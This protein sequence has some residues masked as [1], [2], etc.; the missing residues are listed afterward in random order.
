MSRILK[1]R[2]EQ[3]PMLIPH[4]YAVAGEVKVA[5]GDTDYIPPFF[6]K[7]PSGGT[8]NLVDT[9]YRINAGTSAT[10][11]LQRNGSD[12]TGYTGI[13]VT[14]TS[15]DTNGP[16]TALSNNDMIALVVTSVSG[17]PTNMSFTLFLQY[18]WI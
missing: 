13:S 2:I 4:T 12:I 14:T 8:A 3:I 16:D 7:I 17:T 5:V 10:V 15:S 18:S 11:K 9:R 6:V 1:Q